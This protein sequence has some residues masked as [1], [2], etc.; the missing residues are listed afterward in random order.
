[1]L[2]ATNPE[3]LNELPKPSIRTGWNK[4]TAYAGADYLTDGRTLVL[5]AGVTAKDCC[6]IERR[7][8][9]GR[10][11]ARLVEQIF[12]DQLQA[13]K[14][15]GSLPVKFLGCAADQ[16]LLKCLLPSDEPALPWQRQAMLESAR[17]AYA[18]HLTKATDLRKIPGRRWQN[19]LMLY[20]NDELVG[21][22]YVDWG[23]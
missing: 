14:V 22:V 6:A 23:K 15:N 19:M 2:R 13:V 12:T 16:A 20:R 4:T 7:L 21:I 1:M 3:Q 17:L 18:V 9:G 5:A 8:E 10:D 11:R